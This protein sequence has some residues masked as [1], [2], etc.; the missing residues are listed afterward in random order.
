M[1]HPEIVRFLQPFP[2]TLMCTLDSN[3]L[4][5]VEMY[6]SKVTINLAM[7]GE[8]LGFYSRLPKA[9]VR[10]LTSSPDIA[11]LKGWRDEHINSSRQSRA[12]SRTSQT[13]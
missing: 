12:G 4:C 5:P 13:V 7:N 8:K 11:N 3:P 10:D 2:Q 6:Y 1:I 9:E